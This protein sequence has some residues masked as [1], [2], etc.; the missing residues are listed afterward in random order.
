MGGSPVGE[1][2]SIPGQ[3]VVSSV[4]NN[5][6]RYSM[7]EFVELDVSIFDPEFTL[8][9]YPYLDELYRRDEVI[10]FTSEGMRFLFKFDDCR[11]VMHAKNFQRGTDDP[12]CFSREQDYTRRYIH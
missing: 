3:L 6:G 11:A 12:R 8:N 7:R 1:A 5:L 4:F 10:G 9:P 2:A